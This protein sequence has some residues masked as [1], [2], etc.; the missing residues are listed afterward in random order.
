MA[1]LEVKFGGFLEE[2][3]T[4][5]GHQHEANDTDNPESR[6]HSGRLWSKHE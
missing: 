5:D 3:E 6:G 1:E 2:G 4:I